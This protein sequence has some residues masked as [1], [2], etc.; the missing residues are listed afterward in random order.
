M[1]TGPFWGPVNLDNCDAKYS[2][3]NDLL[4]LN[5]V[6]NLVMLEQSI[7]QVSC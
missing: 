5:K 1:D 6:K 4:T 3:T 2:A 7:L